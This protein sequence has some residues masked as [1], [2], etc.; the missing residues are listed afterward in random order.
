GKFKR[1]SR[2]HR[3]SISQSRNSRTNYP[4]GTPCND[5]DRGG[6]DGQFCRV[7]GMAGTFG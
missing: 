4:L 7:Y 2:T 3:Q 5:G 1:I 6:G